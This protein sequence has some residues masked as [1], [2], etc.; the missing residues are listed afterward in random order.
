MKY[1]LNVHIHS[2]F[3]FTLLLYVTIICYLYGILY[4][5]YGLEK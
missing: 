3:T 5:T 2:T 1:E 4:C